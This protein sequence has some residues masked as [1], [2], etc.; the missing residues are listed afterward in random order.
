MSTAK[1]HTANLGFPRIGP[2]R[3][4]KFALESFWSGKLAEEELLQVAK[5]LRLQNWTIQKQ[6]GIDFI[7]TNDSPL[8]DQVLDALV[9]L[10]ATPERFGEGVVTLPRLFEMA[11]SSAHGSQQHTAM[12]MTKWFDTNYHYLVPEWSEGLKFVPDTSKL[13]AEFGE[14]REVNAGVRPVLLGPISLLL[15]GKVVDVDSGFDPLTLLPR[16]LTAYVQV[17]KDLQSAGADWVQID[18]PCLVTDLSEIHKAAYRTA[19]EKLAGVDVRLMLTTYFDELGD[20]LDLAF[21]LPVAGVHVDLVRGKGQLDAVLDAVRAGQ[22]LS[23]GVVDGRNIWLADLDAASVMIAKAQE[24]IGAD[25]LLIAPSCSLLHVPYDAQDETALPGELQEWLSFAAQKLDEIAWLAGGKEKF[26]ADFA[27]NRRR[28]DRRKVAESSVNT[29]V[30]DALAQL[31]ATDFARPSA[32]PERARKQRNH[33]RLP[34]LPT[35]TIGSFPQTPEVRKQRA[36]WRKGTLQTAEYERFVE[37]ETA[38]CIRRQERIGLDVLVHGEFERNDMVEY[39]GEQ[40]AGFAFTRNGWVQSYGSR[41]VKPPV[42]YGD[43]AR[44]NAMTVRWSS[45]AQSLTGK[46]VKGMLTGPVTILQWSFVRDDVP[47]RDVAWQL[48][49]ALREELLDLEAAGIRVIQLDE[50]ALREGLP[51]RRVA[52]P[53]YLDWAVKAFRIATAK[54]A[55]ETQVH[56]HMCYSEFAEILP[57]IVALDADVL[58]IESARSRM[59][60]LEDF[61][62]HGYPN[63]IGPGVYDIH[64]PRV[65]NEEEITA[66]LQSAL[67]SIGAERLWVNPDCGLKTRGWDEV[68]SALRNMCEA[69]RTVRASVTSDSVA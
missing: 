33:L 21:S 16:M 43:V 19:Y 2:R 10:G 25:R 26:A 14:A 40:L 31:V 4:L 35:T 20:N 39:F 7:P 57:A 34:L 50:P 65:P 52:R 55:D 17:L 8:Y 30:R 1:L 36:A 67:E 48:A 27:E 51:L 63:E 42:I 38:A 22:T 56:T 41:C 24:R 18:E 28:H 49:L 44:P 11:R 23:L 12:E 60:L 69:A 66:L 62:K 64:T 59:E 5:H 45:Y 29:Q 6:R 3:E 54:V 13:L 53:E 47:E 46:P 37:E 58:S 68:E 61:R 15:L 9:L 32:Y